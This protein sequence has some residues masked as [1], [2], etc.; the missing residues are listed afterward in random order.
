MFVIEMKC[1]SLSRDKSNL[2]YDERLKSA[3]NATAQFHLDVRERL[4][5]CSAGLNK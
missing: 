2:D 1:R 3:F 4:V 5:K